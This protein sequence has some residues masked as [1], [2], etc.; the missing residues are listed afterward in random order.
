MNTSLWIP[1]YVAIG[2]NLDDPLSQVRAA[3]DALAGLERSR[4]IARSRLYRTRPLGPQDQPDFINAA[5]GLL[6]LLSPRQL[7]GALK[8]IESALGRRAPLVRWGPRR[9]DLDLLLHGDARLSE[10]DLVIPHA[11]LPRRN[12]VL[13]PL[14]DI[15][16]DLIVAPHGRISDLAA[17]AG[18][19]GLAL[20]EDLND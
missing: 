3:F 11:G 13:Y 14:R 18:S 12:F 20:L 1:A 6:T 8:R 2:S 15:A 5:A 16:P 4:L 19:D 10:A 17:R 9:I 7:L